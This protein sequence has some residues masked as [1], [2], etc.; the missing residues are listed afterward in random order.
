MHQLEE[1]QRASVEGAKYAQEL[2]RQQ[3]QERSSRRD[4]IEAL[5][6]IVHADAV[7]KSAQDVYRTAGSSMHESSDALSKLAQKSYRN[8]KRMLKAREAKEK[9]AV[10]RM[11]NLPQASSQTPA[12][13]HTRAE[14]QIAALVTAT[15][16]MVSLVKDPNRGYAGSLGVS[17]VTIAAK[18][19]RLSNL[20]KLEKRFQRTNKGNKL[21]LGL[22]NLASVPASHQFEDEE[23]AAESA[24]V[25]TKQGKM[26]AGMA[27]SIKDDSVVGRDGAA[28]T[29]EGDLEGEHAWLDKDQT[30]PEAAKVTARG[31]AAAKAQEEGKPIERVEEMKPIKEEM[32]PIKE[33]MKPIKKQE[34]ENAVA[35]LTDVVGEQ[36]TEAES[37]LPD[38][39]SETLNTP[40][41]H[42][43]VAAAETSLRT[44]TKALSPTPKHSD[45][46]LQSDTVASEKLE[47]SA[48]KHSLGGMAMKMDAEADKDAEA[49]TMLLKLSSSASPE[50]HTF[51]TGMAYF[52]A[53]SLPSSS[54]VVAASEL[55]KRLQRVTRRAM[56]RVH[57]SSLE[58]GID[59]RFQLQ[60]G[61]SPAQ[62]DALK[63]RSQ[64]AGMARKGL[65]SPAQA[66]NLNTLAAAAS[67][68]D[69]R[70]WRALRRASTMLQTISWTPEEV[71][72][73]VKRLNGR[74]LPLTLAQAL[75]S[76]VAAP[77]RLR[78]LA[79]LGGQLRSVEAVYGA[80]FGAK[81]RPLSA[82]AAKYKQ[83]L[84]Q[85]SR[86]DVKEGKPGQAVQRLWSL[87]A[88]TKDRHLQHQLSKVLDSDAAAMAQ[89]EVG[90]QL[91]ERV[92]RE[93]ASS[94][95]RELLTQSTWMGRML[96]QHASDSAAAKAVHKNLRSVQ[97]TLQE[98]E[99]S[100]ELRGASRV[101]KVLREVQKTLHPMAVL[102]AGLLLR[103]V[104][105]LAN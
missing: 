24:M 96:D 63:V 92:V 4:Q 17:A 15:S 102:Q 60:V 1:A 28:G 95:F 49:T 22:K 101:R 94:L 10:I 33:E 75:A 78:C 72:T 45:R 81:A 5:Q 9:A 62:L 86:M 40:P 52:E 38:G 87:A 97:R 73:G 103:A 20:L 65:L 7:G 77:I 58:A 41:G 46:P 25:P 29:A 93:N 27:S 35:P 74:M 64:L 21:A 6:A 99:A 26:L 98:T 43:E 100:G 61:G 31:L 71:A 2:S 82:G 37:V 50:T 90:A 39:S 42:L 8:A 3:M 89:V 80:S 14:D 83:A 85:E 76:S 91:A 19:R 84:L 47:R 34:E 57:V 54:K 13:L 23:K 44:A 32:K 79:S 66:F 105:A 67:V 18:A 56:K 48:E 59:G 104:P 68:G 36:R 16:H 30:T 51:P 69:R 70:A 55:A 11:R 88:V 12:E 53:I